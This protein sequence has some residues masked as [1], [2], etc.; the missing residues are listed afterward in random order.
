MRSS[1]PGKSTSARKKAAVEV[2]SVSPHGLWLSV[3]GEEHL[4]PFDDHPWFR[5]ARVDEVF[6]VQ[7]LHG[8]HLRWPDLDVDLH[9]DSLR[10]PGKFPLMDRA[11]R[12]SRR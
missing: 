2:L 8:S 7:L 5:N 6:N 10:N 1:K 11:R 3:A 4:L 9:V 12:V